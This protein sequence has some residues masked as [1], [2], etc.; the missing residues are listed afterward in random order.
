MS[1]WSRD[2]FSNLLALEISDRASEL[3]RQEAV[4]LFDDHHALHCADRPVRTVSEFQ[5]HDF[6]GVGNKPSKPPV[7]F[8]VFGQP[9]NAVADGRVYGRE[10]RSPTAGRHLLL[11]E[12]QPARPGR[13]PHPRAARDGDKPDLLGQQ[14]ETLDGRR[15][16]PGW[17]LDI[18]RGL[19]TPEHQEVRCQQRMD[20]P[21]LGRAPIHPLHTPRLS[22]RTP[23]PA[24][25]MLLPV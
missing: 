11:R 23:P 25:R 10:V 17:I 21:V 22:V 16:E 8:E 12:S 18:A 15:N 13:Y 1:R 14:A 6:V 5:L 7:P 2:R 20:R 24:I 4:E 9:P 3:D 19:R